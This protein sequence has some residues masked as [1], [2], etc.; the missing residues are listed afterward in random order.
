M[1]DREFRQRVEEALSGIPDGTTTEVVTW[2]DTRSPD[3]VSSDG[4]STQVLISLEGE[5]QDDDL[6]SYDE[7]EPTLHA[8]GLET[9][10]AG[11]YAVFADVNERT[12][13]DLRRAETISLPVVAILA[14]LIFGSLVAASMPVLVGALAV[15]GAMAVIRLLTLFTD[16]SIFSINVITLLGMGLAI[17]YALF[18]VSRF[19]E[20]LARRPVDDPASVGDALR[21]TMQTAGRTVLFSG[22]TVAAAMSSLLVFPQAFL[23]SMGYG[24]IAAVLVAM[25][26]A[27]TVLPATLRLL[28]RRID[29]GRVLRRRR[30]EDDHGVLGP[31]RR[32][33][34]APA[35]ARPGRGDRRAAGA[36]L[37]VPRR[38]VGLGRPP[39]PAPRRPVVRR[40]GEARR[41]VRL[42][43]VD[44]PR[45]CST[46]P[47]RPTSAPTPATLEDGRRGDGGAAGR[48]GR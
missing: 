2:Y 25:L 8:E 28:G 1:Q 15:V 35:G 45:C 16:V 23:R 6:A 30:T 29:K 31:D 34:D 20:E 40:H 42:R 9:D 44:A 13:Q 43:D 48:R 3:L 41:R 36:R 18:V 4:H 5:T 7:I 32:R 22:L 24:G 33:R 12:E 14:V 11:T 47:T 27:L 21:T 17:D 26:A 10:L 39:D 46:A 37:A 19:R 38:Q